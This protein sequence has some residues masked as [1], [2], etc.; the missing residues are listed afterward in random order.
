M[1]MSMLRFHKS[2][3]RLQR[4]ALSSTRV[5]SAAESDTIFALSSA[6]GKAGVAV[7]RISGESA[8]PCLRAL[9]KSDKLPLPRT[10]VHATTAAVCALSCLRANS[11]SGG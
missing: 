9:S 4:R 1:M 2:L 7:I 3:C 11:Y 5:L 10:Y 8:E 6:E